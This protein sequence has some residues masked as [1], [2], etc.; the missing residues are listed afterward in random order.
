LSFRRSDAIRAS[1]FS[2][3]EE[4]FMK[5]ALLWLDKCFEE[6]ALVLLM[7][8]ISCTMFL[9]IIMRYIFEMPLTWPEEIS[10]YMWIW[11]V[12]FSMSYA[13][14]VGNV[15]RVD[16]LTEF[17]PKNIKRYLE[18]FLQSIALAVYTVFS[19]YSVI[20]LNSLIISKRVSPALRIPMYLVYFVVCIGFFLSFLRT[21]QLL[22]KLFRNKD[23]SSSGDDSIKMMGVG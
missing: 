21:G 10:R 1:G 17:L 5:K 11:T 4:I 8:G 12:F 18:I 9:Q 20:V 2:S 7:I 3:S 19:Y 6:T 14:K 16:V 22:V 15:L 13:I 23:A